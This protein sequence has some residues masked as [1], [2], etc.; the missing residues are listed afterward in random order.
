MEVN[1]NDEHHAN[2]AGK[3]KNSQRNYYLYSGRSLNPGQASKNAHEN[4]NTNR[5]HVS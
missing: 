5:G 2:L 3:G 4:G 1:Q